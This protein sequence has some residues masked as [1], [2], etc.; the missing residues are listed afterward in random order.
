VFLEKLK[1]YSHSPTLH[2]PPDGYR[3]KPVRYIIELRSDG[4][5]AN[6]VP[7]D[8]ADSSSRKTRRGV[9]RMVP[10]IRR[11]GSVLRPS[12]LA[13]STAY[14][15]GI[16]KSEKEKDVK[17]AAKCQKAFVDLVRECA[18]E[19]EDQAVWAVLRFVEDDPLQKLQIGEDFDAT[20]TITFRVDGAF[21]VD[22]PA[23]RSFWAH[24]Q[25]E[26]EKKRM[27]CVVCGE[28]RPVLERLPGVIKG[29]PGGQSSGTSIISANENAFE[30]YGLEHSL[31]APVCADCA[32]RFTFALNSLLADD[33][34][35]LRIGKSVFVYW[36]QK[37]VEFNFLTALSD[38]DPEAVRALLESPWGKKAA[39]VEANR[40]YAA[41][42]GA[43]GGRTQ[44]REW[45]DISIDEVQHNLLRWFERL[46]IVGPWGEEP[47]PLAIRSLAAA[48][49]R[50]LRDVAPHTMRGLLLSAIMGRPLPAKLPRLAAQRT[51]VEQTVYHN[52]AAVIKLGY[53]SRHPNK[54]GIMIELDMS[55]TEPGYLCGR[56]L[57]EL[58]QAQRAASPGVKAT[59]VD[60]Y[61]G[62]ACT[63][64]GTVFGTL[65]QTAQAHLGKLKRD[66]P[67]AYF[68]IQS[69]I[70]DILAGLSA[71][72]KTLTMDE[73]A[74]FALGYYHQ[75]A[76]NRAQALAHK[77]ENQDE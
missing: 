56:L 76:H 46:R 55:S 16:P 28:R 4:S 52:H 41:V 59:I 73:Q 42:L 66:N 26:G 60:R 9:A 1:E 37:P 30:S 43:S 61:Y 22:R 21:P 14:T 70:E 49:V 18:Q 2:M 19:T 34:H 29:V 64:P 5:L 71:F 74:L 65:V 3:E 47:R 25:E 62:T 57:A 39:A 44:V 20:S 7:T 77:K 12:L 48:T 32:R 23:V 72:P 54:E 69:T 75:R 8:T 17:R 45:I 11:A 36:T 50:D 63:A 67:P 40:F 51:R 27:Q 10:E 33:Q 13:D 58:E 24:K 53:L 35:H 68:G 6:P 15:L 38:P 31:I